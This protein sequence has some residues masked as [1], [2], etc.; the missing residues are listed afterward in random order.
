MICIPT[1]SLTLTTL[2]AGSKGGGN[3]CLFPPECTLKRACQT[4]EYSVC[5]ACCSGDFIPH[6][7]TLIDQARWAVACHRNSEIGEA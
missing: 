2:I 5:L 4:N 7:V 6:A 1:S 3:L